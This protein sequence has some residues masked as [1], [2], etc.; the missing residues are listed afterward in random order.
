MSVDAIMKEIKALSAA[1]RDELK[2]QFL[3]EFPDTESEGELSPELKALLDE[4]DAAY[5]ANPT[6]LYTWE[7][8]VAYVKR[9]R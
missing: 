7:E 2:N 5:E 3:G 4:R 9:P 1:E 6:Q 8:V